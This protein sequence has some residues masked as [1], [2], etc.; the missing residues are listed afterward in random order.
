MSL[1]LL[2]HYY[3]LCFTFFIPKN[4][5]AFRRKYLHISSDKRGKTPIIFDPVDLFLRVDEG[6][7]IRNVAAF[8]VLRVF[9]DFLRKGR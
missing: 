8:K 1:A 6:R 7:S 4:V 2:L 5:I 3:F 9:L